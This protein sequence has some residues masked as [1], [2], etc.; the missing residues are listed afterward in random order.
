MPKVAV[1]STNFLEYSQT[2]VHEEI[3]HHSR[4][5]VEVFARKRHNAERFPFEPLHLGGLRY[6][7]TRRDPRFDRAF[8]ERSFAL[9]HGHFGTGSLYAQP[10]AERYGLPLVVTFHGYDV[11][12]LRSFAR[13]LPKNW[14]Y[15]LLAPSLLRRI[16][17][18]LC[19]SKELLELLAEAGMPRER[20][21][22]YHLGI[23]LARFRYSGR[24]P[25][26]RVLMVGR[27]VEKKGFEYGIR[28]FAQALRAGSLAEL[29]IVGGGEY[30]ARLRAV[31][32]ELGIAPNVHFQGVLASEQIATLLSESDV[33]MAPSVVAADGDRESG[34][35]ALKE[36]SAS[37]AAVLGTYHGGI[38]EIIE[39]GVT[40]FLVPERHYELLGVRLHALLSDRER[41]R[42][43]GQAGRAKMEREYDL[44]TQ[45][46]ELETRY[47]EAVAMF[48]ASH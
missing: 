36:A 32:E 19:A 23:D 38:P 5:E 26:A 14:P 3:T 22:L 29:L 7:L 4:Y 17:L 18:G 44:T 13:L 11:P 10:Y 40:G 35:I 42:E 9:V 43:M 15:A 21:R 16:T 24:R 48:G 8:R 1:F 46:A 30:E 20:L 39:D 27:F 12:L 47:D 34:V 33:L 45:V 31:V 37:G 41:A 2:F 25:L 28:A 6:A